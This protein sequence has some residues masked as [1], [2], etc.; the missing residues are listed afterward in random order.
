MS[1]ERLERSRRGR[2]CRSHCLG[3][4]V[5]T[6]QLLKRARLNETS[7]FVLTHG[8]L[9]PKLHVWLRTRLATDEEIEAPQTVEELSSPL[10]DRTE[11]ACD[12]HLFKV[13]ERTRPTGQ[14]DP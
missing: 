8:G 2:C 4:D 7:D 11:D 12:A 13:R 1:Q 6:H 9:P 10:S 3:D 14:P 5:P